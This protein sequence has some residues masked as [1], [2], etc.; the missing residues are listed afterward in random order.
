MKVMYWGREIR[1]KRGIGTMRGGGNKYV[2]AISKGQC[3]KTRLQISKK[4]NFTRKIRHRY[5]A[6]GSCVGR[7]FLCACVRCSAGAGLE[8][9][10]IIV[11]IRTPSITPYLAD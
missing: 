10:A 9:L 1:G 4:V 6:S 11:K 7:L 3:Q 8:K 5:A 2:R